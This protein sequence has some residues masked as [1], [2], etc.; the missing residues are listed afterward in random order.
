MNETL[1]LVLALVTGVLLGAMFFG[2][3]WWTVR[4]G[5]S[6]KRPALWF[7]GSLLLRTS[8]ALAGFYFI[9]RGHWERLLVCLLGFV[10]ARLIVTRLTGSPVKATTPQRRRPAMR[11]SPDEMHLL[12]TRVSQTQRHHCVHVGT[13]ARAGRRFKTHHAQTFHGSETFPLAEPSGNRRHRH[14]ETNRRGRPEP[15]ARSISAFWARSS[16]SSP[17][18]ASAPSFPATSRRLA[19]SRP[20]LH[21]RCACLWPCRSSASRSKGWATT[22]SPM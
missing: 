3:L 7:L 9:A 16:C 21:S 11:L 1:T 10:I 12:A 17:Q 13:D 8:I 20:R 14:R 15:A 18:P 2:G 4:K 6:S 5:V 22:S 19:R